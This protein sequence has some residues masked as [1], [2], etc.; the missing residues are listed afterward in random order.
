MFFPKQSLLNNPGPCPVGNGHRPL[1]KSKTQKRR[2]F[3][4]ANAISRDSASTQALAHGTQCRLS[5]SHIRSHNVAHDSITMQSSARAHVRATAGGECSLRRN[6]YS[7]SIVCGC[8]Q[9]I[10]SLSPKSDCTANA[11]KRA[12]STSS[13]WFTAKRRHARHRTP[14]TKT[15]ALL[16]REPASRKRH[17]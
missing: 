12:R 14:K 6:K 4:N 17:S 16:P 5:N 9:R 10:A 15:K 2:C 11:V 3:N 8:P 13:L 7:P 1:T